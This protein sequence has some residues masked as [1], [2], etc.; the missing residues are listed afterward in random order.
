MSTVQGHA[1]ELV[2]GR[3]GETYVVLMRGRFHFYEGYEVSKG[4]CRGRDRTC[5]SLCMCVRMCVLGWV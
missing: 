3:L 5:R 1:G 2:F 4:A